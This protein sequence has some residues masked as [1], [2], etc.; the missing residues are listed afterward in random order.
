MSTHN[1][2]RRRFIAR[3]AGALAAGS[4]T[5]LAL[6]GAALAASGS[7]ERILVVL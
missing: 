2:G 7:E 6:P 1:V 4:C 3:A 5:G